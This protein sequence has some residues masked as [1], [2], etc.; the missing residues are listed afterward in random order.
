MPSLSSSA[1]AGFVPINASILSGILSLSRSDIIIF[2]M[3]I[4]T[5]TLALSPAVL[6][7]MTVRLYSGTSLAFISTAVVRTPLLAMVK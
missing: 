5:S 6:V 1:I 7:A 4:L 2:S 3:L